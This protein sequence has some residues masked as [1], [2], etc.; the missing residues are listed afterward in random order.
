MLVS[1]MPHLI[2]SFRDYIVSEKGLSIHTAKA[3]ER[4]LNKLKAFLQNQD[5]N[6]LDQESFSL[7]LGALKDRGLASSTIARHVFSCRVFFRYLERE[8]PHQAPHLSAVSAPKGESKVPR[9]LTPSDMQALLS[10]VHSSAVEPMMTALIEVLYATGVRVSE[11]CS[12][13]WVDV[14][15][16]MIKVR[17][18]GEKERLV[19]LGSKA[20]EA[21]SRYA[22][23]FKVMPCKMSPLFLSKRG[24]RA[25]R[26][27]IWSCIKTCIRGAGIEK[28]ISPHSFRHTFATHLL[29]GG[30][31]LRVIQEFLGHSDISTTDRYTHISMRKL[32]DDFHKFHPERKI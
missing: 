25:S 32:Q 18:K 23:S 24:K 28:N 8:F 4:D 27:Y 1:K 5:L 7:F 2:I 10:F 15:Q 11:L 22:D 19:P 29:E 9:V 31:D 14:K 17:G 6:Q 21:L 20:R 12:L 16:S 26:Q 30:A 3:Y 13:N